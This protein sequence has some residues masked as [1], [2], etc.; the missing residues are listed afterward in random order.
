[1]GGLSSELK[2]LPIP[3]DSGM[4]G[5]AIFELELPD[6][7]LIILIARDNDFMQ[8]SGSTILKGNDTLL[9]L[10]DAKSFDEVINRFKIS[11]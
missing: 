8:P 4:D 3:I 6:D 1:M 7:F 9:V 10:S 5:K 11:E 2:E